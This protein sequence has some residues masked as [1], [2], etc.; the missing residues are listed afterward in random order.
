MSKQN[1]SEFDI[2]EA[3]KDVANLMGV[4]ARTAPKSAG[5]DFVVVKAIYGEDV[6]KLADEMIHYG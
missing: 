4:A 5:K 6:A 2:Q 1:L 3:I